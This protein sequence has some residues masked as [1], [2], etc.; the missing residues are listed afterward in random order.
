MKAEADIA[1]TAAAAAAAVHG[2]GEWRAR[3]RGVERRRC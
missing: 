3:G 1:S 2:A